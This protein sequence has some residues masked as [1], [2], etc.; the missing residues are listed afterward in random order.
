MVLLENHLDLPKSSLEG[1]EIPGM[2]S[3]MQPGLEQEMSSS[4]GLAIPPWNSPQPQSQPCIPIPTSCCSPGVLGSCLH[5]E[6]RVGIPAGRGP[7][8]RRCRCRDPGWDRTPARSCGTSPGA[9]TPTATQ[10]SCLERES[11]PGAGIL[12]WIRNLCLDR[13]SLPGL[14]IPA[15]DW[16]SP[17]ESG[18]PAGAGIPI[19]WGS[20]IL[21]WGGNSPRDWEFPPGSEILTWIRNP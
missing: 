12:L 8:P 14:G 10:G 20:G 9:P 16:E 19:T 4:P 21:A 3:W 7:S 15:L 2:H 6:N 17:P 18:I 11:L 5:S 13:E 1:R